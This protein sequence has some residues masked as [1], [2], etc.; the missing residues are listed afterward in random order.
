M[1]K[2]LILGSCGML[3]S[4]LCEYLLQNNYQVIGI[5]KIN[6][7][8]KFEKYKLYNIDLLDFLKLKKLYF[9]KNLIL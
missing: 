2:V 4:V 6:L 1:K 7:E 8:N 5:D 3:G 9:R